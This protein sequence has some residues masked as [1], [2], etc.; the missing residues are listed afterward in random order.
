MCVV[1]FLCA[2]WVGCLGLLLAGVGEVRCQDPAGA[3]A[4]K[5]SAI[6][7]RYQDQKATLKQLSVK[8]VLTYVLQVDPQVAARIDGHTDYLITEVQAAFKGPHRLYDQHYRLTSG[9][10]T[11]LG[12]LRRT[13]VAYDGETTQL[14]KSWWDPKT[15]ADWAR[16]TRGDTTDQFD[17][18]DEYMACHGLPKAYI[19]LLGEPDPV[20]LD[21]A[22]FLLDDTYQVEPGA[23]PAEDGTP[24]IVVKGGRDRIWFDPKLG[25]A[26]RQREWKHLEYP[27]P[28]R[29]LRFADHSEVTR[30]LWLAKTVYLDFFCDPSKHSLPA[31][32]PYKTGVLKVTEL[33]VE[34]LPDSLFQIHLE[35]GTWIEDATRFQRQADGSLPIVNYSIP[36]QPADLDGIIQ[37]ATEQR[38]LAED[39]SARRTR[40][41]RG[42]LV[43]NV[44]LLL[45]AGA[46][47]LYRR[48][49]SRQ[50]GAS[51]V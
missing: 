45:A 33:K 6:R 24:C 12:G 46:F 36:V 15:T 13:A 8:W 50:A 18:R 49:K 47:I 35:P 1:R 51:P 38:R 30:G 14:F 17:A 2:G 43:A 27:W 9:K 32:K 10:K 29:R 11:A 44:T 42:I 23:R 19:R 20:P 25:F 16:L 37:E 21:L 26:L 39:A 34:T 48:R 41:M 31:G 5:V 22:E 40:L 3:L 28:A 7:A 4:P